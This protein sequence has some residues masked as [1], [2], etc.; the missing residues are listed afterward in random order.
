MTNPSLTPDEQGEIDAF[1]A[2]IADQPT[3][4][5]TDDQVVFEPYNPDQPPVD[6]VAAYRATH[7]T[8]PAQDQAA[9]AE[10]LST[11]NTRLGGPKP[12][13]DDDL[14]DLNP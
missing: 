4:P 8:V 14:L 7:P 10:W 12:A 13:H 2:R 1:L 9:H 6:R 5:P 11:R 3:W